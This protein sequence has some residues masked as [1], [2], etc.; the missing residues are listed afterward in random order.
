MGFEVVGVKGEFFIHDYVPAVQS[1][2]V[3]ERAWEFI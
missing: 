3:K 2:Q 1:L